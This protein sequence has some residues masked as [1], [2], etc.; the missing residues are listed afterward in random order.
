[1][2]LQMLQLADARPADSVIDI[3]GGAAPLTDALLA[4]GFTDVTVLDISR[5]GLSAAQRRLGPAAQLVRWVHADITRWRPERRYRIWHDRAVFHFLT[6]PDAQESYFDTLTAAVEP[7]GSVI[8]G[9]FAADG[10][11]QCSG[12]PVARYS[13]TDLKKLVS[14]YLTVLATEREEHTTPAGAT[15]PFTWLLGRR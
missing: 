14:P 5:T 3:G 6:T 12:L 15:Q 1:M 7:G 10:P 4:Q 8:I 13:P 11:E 9:S 2:S